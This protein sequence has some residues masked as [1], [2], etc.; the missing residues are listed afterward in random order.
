MLA[1]VAINTLVCAMFTLQ[2]N[3]SSV[4][5]DPSDAVQR[6]P[7]EEQDDLC[8]ANI[9]FCKN[10]GDPLYSNVNTHRNDKEEEED[11]VEYTFVN[12]KSASASPE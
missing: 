5:D 11:C 9:R 3:M 4:C 12:I 2:P 10:R 7:A 1:N 6:K 8:Y